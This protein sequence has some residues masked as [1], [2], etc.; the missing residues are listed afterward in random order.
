MNAQVLW[1][2]WRRILKEDAL[3][4]ALFQPDFSERAR[5]FGL[6][7]EQT[8]IAL[9]YA[10]TPKQTRWNIDTYRFRS[11]KVAVSALSIA[12]PITWRLLLQRGHDVDALSHAYLAQV[13][14]VDEGPFTHRICA[15][16]LKFLS[17]GPCLAAQDP[18][19]RELIAF[20]AATVSLL[21]SLA[22]RRIS[23]PDPAWQSLV[24][25]EDVRFVQ[26]RQAIVIDTSLDVTPW[27]RDPALIGV[28][29]L[30]VQNLS[31]LRY[32]RSSDEAPG[33]ITLRERS[34]LTYKLLAEP[35]S[36]PELSELLQDEARD[37]ASATLRR[38]LSLGVVRPV[39]ASTC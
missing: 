10:R 5:E 12:A 38:F 13:G 9:A 27:L 36:V 31:L 25:R 24:D 33:L 29:P 3:Q 7:E 1:K 15:G 16:M 23:A 2:V 32:V 22:G 4:A 21:L 37:P 17:A 18:E 14:W 39:E 35:H 20:E 26:S 28:V 34:Q 6:D 11:G 8:A 30:S 19:L